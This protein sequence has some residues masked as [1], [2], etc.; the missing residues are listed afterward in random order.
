MTTKKKA[1]NCMTHYYGCDCNRYR[2]E[3]M[4]S[5][6]KVI[7]TW[8]SFDFDSCVGCGF[9]AALDPEAVVNLCDKALGRNE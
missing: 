9:L 3:Q 8:A 2:F 4:E 5:A 1:D 7:R 6:L